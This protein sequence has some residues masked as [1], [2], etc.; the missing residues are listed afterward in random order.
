MNWTPRYSKAVP[1]GAGNITLRFTLDARYRPELY[2]GNSC[3]N[4]SKYNC[5][6]CTQGGCNFDFFWKFDNRSFPRVFAEKQSSYTFMPGLFE[7]QKKHNQS[8]Q[9]MNQNARVVE[10]VK[11]LHWLEWQVHGISPLNP[12]FISSGLQQVEMLTVSLALWMV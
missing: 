4:A 2:G 8:K 1:D 9:D 6:L 10:S 7:S 5:S 3:A 11:W 12:A